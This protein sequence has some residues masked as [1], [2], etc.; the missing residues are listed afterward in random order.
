MQKSNREACHNADF[1]SIMERC[2]F[3]KESIWF[4]ELYGFLFHVDEKE[5]G[6]PN[7]FMTS[8][9]FAM[10]GMLEINP[11]NVDADKCQTLHDAVN[12][13]YQKFLADGKPEDCDFLPQGGFAPRLIRLRYDSGMRFSDLRFTLNMAAK[14]KDYSDGIVN[15]RI[16]MRCTISKT[17]S[18]NKRLS[19]SATSRR[20]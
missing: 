3:V 10:K 2:S 19:G 1:L 20:S 11:S 9:I 13:A 8:R 12:Q 17:S 5:Y 18:G 15:E 6:K 7:F 14:W 16:G 4:M